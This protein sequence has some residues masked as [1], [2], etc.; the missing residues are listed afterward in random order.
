VE[1]FAAEYLT[2]HISLVNV[3]L[4]GL[5]EREDREKLRCELRSCGFEDLLGAKVRK[6]SREYYPGLHVEL[7]R[8]CWRGHVDGWMVF[9]VARG[10]D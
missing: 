10:E 5:A 3:L 7:Q 9:Y 4:E 6:A 8:W 2:A 1:W